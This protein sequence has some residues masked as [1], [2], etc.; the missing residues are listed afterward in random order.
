MIYPTIHLNG[1]SKDGLRDR[2][3]EAAESVR[4]AIRAVK[5]TEPHSR[6]YYVKIDDGVALYRQATLEHSS[7][8]WRLNEVLRELEDLAQHIDGIIPGAGV[9]PDPDA[10][11]LVTAASEA[12][13]QF[14]DDEL[15]QAAF[16]KHVG[17]IAP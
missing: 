11:A 4:D 12:T 1:T 15:E 7:R 2:L 6:D 13:E 16:W 10:H 9:Q 17:N 3:V 14:T 8:L 5:Q